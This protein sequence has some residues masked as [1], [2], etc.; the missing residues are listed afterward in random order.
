[1]DKDEWEDQILKQ[2]LEM[3]RKM[4]MDVD[5]DDLMRMM[6]QIQSQFDNLGIDPEKIRSGD[7]KINLQSDFGDIGEILGK[8]APDISSILDQM[9]VDI[10]MGKKSE[11]ELVEI[12]IEEESEDDDDSVN[13]IPIADV[14]VDG[15][16]MNI[17]I[18][19]SRHDGID[20]S[21]VELNLTGGGSTLHLMRATQ[22]HPIQRFELPKAAESVDNWEINNGILDITFTLRE[23]KESVS[24]KGGN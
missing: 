4:G 3:F 10:K 5:E 7:V 13:S 6:D 2:M 8:G 22:L 18:D 23:P 24:P 15:D 20:D 19:V 17:T 12:E 21:E 16:S 14:Y 11:P 9:G 1:M